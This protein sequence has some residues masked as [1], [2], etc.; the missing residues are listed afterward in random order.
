M[1]VGSWY[2]IIFETRFMNNI[3]ILLTRYMVTV[4]TTMEDLRD[5]VLSPQDWQRDI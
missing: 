3:I 2:I 4:I 5:R 1:L